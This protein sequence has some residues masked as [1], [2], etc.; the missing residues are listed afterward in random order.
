MIPTKKTPEL[1][2]YKRLARR[3]TLAFFAT[4]F[5]LLAIFVLIMMLLEKLGFSFRTG[6]FSA[7][8]SLSIY[9]ISVI[10]ASAIS[11]FAVW[12]I[13]RPLSDLS[14]GT[15]KIAE[16]DYSVRLEYNG[17]LREL[18]ET[19]ENFNYMA[20]ELSSIELIRNDFIANVSHEFKTPLS[21]LNGYLT[22]LQDDSISSEERNEYISK[23]FF[24][25]EKLNDLTDN[26]L[27]LS[28]LEHQVSLD[29]PTSF[30][31]DEQLREAIV[32]L[33]PKWS[34]KNINFDLELPEL[35][36]CNQRSLLF[37]VWTNLISNAIKFSEDGEPITVKIEESEHHYKVYISDSGIGMTEEQQRHIFD[38]FYQAD[39]SRQAHGNGLGLALCKEIISKCDGKIYVTSKLGEG[40]VFLVSLRKAEK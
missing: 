39:S 27:R 10:L 18:A 40:S 28:K 26:I 8:G 25:I 36:I 19:V 17:R 1:K 21:S 12:N 4:I 16:G 2:H 35:T 31:L 6:T 3:L 38:K 29:E 37:Q 15:R 20:Q 9:I 23:S 5:I 13:F 34:R 33:E 7:F 14:K 30:R 11:Y 24:S 32:L 22:L